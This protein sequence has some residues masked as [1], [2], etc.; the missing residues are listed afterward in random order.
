MKE[1]KALKGERETGEKREE[2]VEKKGKERKRCEGGE[3]RNM[4]FKK[5]CI[6][7]YWQLQQVALAHNV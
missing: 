3:D 2:I 1:E 6:L 5:S 4:S 7:N